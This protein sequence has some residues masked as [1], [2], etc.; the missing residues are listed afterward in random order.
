MR[1]EIYW[2]VTCDVKPGK[3]QDFTEAIEPLV[4][5]TKAEEGSLIYGYSV[6]D[7]ETLVHILEM[8]RDSAAVVSHVTTVFPQFAERFLDGVDIT[9]FVVFGTP[10]AAAK[11][12]LDGF[13]STYMRPF[14][15]FTRK[16]SLVS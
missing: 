8:Y 10:D 14:S 13:G 12:I 4:A 1:E 11:E 2:L 6:N 7:D 3:F 5:A 15:G 9:G 16:E